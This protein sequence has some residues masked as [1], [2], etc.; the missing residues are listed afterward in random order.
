M[1]DYFYTVFPGQLRQLSYSKSDHITNRVLRL[2]GVPF[3]GGPDWENVRTDLDTVPAS[4]RTRFVLALFMIVL[5]DQALYTYNREAYGNGGTGRLFRSSAGP[6][7]AR[8]SKTRSNS[9]GRRSGKGLS[10]LH[11]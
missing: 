6:A 9:C 11:G 2:G 7:S 3:F 10:T 4:D 5:T 1:Q 8:I